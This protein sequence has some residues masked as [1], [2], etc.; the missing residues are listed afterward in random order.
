MSAIP[1]SPSASRIPRQKVTVRPPRMVLPRRF[2][3]AQGDEGIEDGV[4]GYVQA[5]LGPVEKL[6]QARS[7]EILDVGVVELCPETPQFP[8]GPV[9]VGARPASRHRQH[10][11]LRQRDA[12]VDC[13]GKLPVK[14]Q[15]VHHGCR[16]DPVVLLSVHLE[17]AGRAE[18][19]RPEDVVVRGIDIRR[20][21]QEMEILHVQNPG[22]LVGT[23]Q[24]PSHPAEVPSFPPAHCGVHDPQE[25]LAG[26]DDLLQELVRDPSSA[27]LPRRVLEVEVEPVE[28]LPHLHRDVLADP[29]G[30]F[31][32]LGHAGKDGVGAVGVENE[33]AN[34]M[35][36]VRLPI[37]GGEVLPVSAGQDQRRPLLG[38]G[39]GQF[40]AGQGGEGPS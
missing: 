24:H 10:R 6:V 20:G 15:K 28:G 32:G 30:V 31:P 14:H 19:R 11:F 38:L 26:G 2:Q 22:G 35:V 27:G 7:E 36:A 37:P 33:K 13:P 3:R 8:F 9:S 5:G 40:A 23:L 17:R 1:T 29:A 12:M 4:P 25:H 16:I 39:A 34:D 21:G 18:H